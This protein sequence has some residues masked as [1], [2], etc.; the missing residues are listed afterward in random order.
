MLQKDGKPSTHVGETK[1]NAR[2]VEVS[3]QSTDRAANAGKATTGNFF[4]TLVV[5]T[6]S[7]DNYGSSWSEA[8]KGISSAFLCTGMFFLLFSVINSVL[9]LLAVNETEDDYQATRLLQRLELWFTLPSIYFYLGVGCGSFGFMI[10]FPAAFPLKYALFNIAAGIAIIALNAP[11]YQFL[12]LCVY[13]TRVEANLRIPSHPTWLVWL[14]ML[15]RK[16]SKD[17]A[18][19]TK[20]NQDN[21]SC[22]TPAVDDGNSPQ[23]AVVKVLETALDSIG[24]IDLLPLFIDNGWDDIDALAE[25]REHHVAQIA[26][27]KPG[28]IARFLRHLRRQL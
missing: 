10:W 7:F 5:A 20:P 16:T 23:D 15:G 28:H 18:T 3:G 14:P 11:Y 22:V 17:E 12:I 24:Q 4:Q 26:T 1:M 19:P 25:L 9:V 2:G 6:T 27:L 8:A 21:V 13:D